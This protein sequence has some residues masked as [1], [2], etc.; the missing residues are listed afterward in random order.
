MAVGNVFLA[1]SKKNL[2]D[3]SSLEPEKQNTLKKNPESVYFC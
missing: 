3:D 1:L 2:A